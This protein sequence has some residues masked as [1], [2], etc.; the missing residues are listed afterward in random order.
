MKFS[1][2]DGDHLLP[3][4]HAR[5]VNCHRIR[6]IHRAVVV[7]QLA[8]LVVTPGRQGAVPCQCQTVIS[9]CSDLLDRFARQQTRRSQ[10]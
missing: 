2:S 9:S 5:D 8:I 1:R 4:K 3:G 10:W 7:T 6:T